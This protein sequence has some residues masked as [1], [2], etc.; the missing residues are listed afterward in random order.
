[1]DN[2]KHEKDLLNLEDDQNKLPNDYNFL[3]QKLRS[4]RK[5]I[6]LLEKNF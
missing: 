3:V 6:S 2:K 1:M 5:I 4:I